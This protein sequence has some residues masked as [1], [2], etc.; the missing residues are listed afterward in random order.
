V[1]WFLKEHLPLALSSLLLGAWV[2][3][4][5]DL[6][7]FVFLAALFLFTMVFYLD[8]QIPSHFALAVSLAGAAI[9]IN[10][11]I[12]LIYDQLISHGRAY[13]S[14]NLIPIIPVVSLLCGQLIFVMKGLAFNS[15]R[16]FSSV[17]SVFGLVIS[18]ISLLIMSFG[19]FSRM[20]VK[21][22]RDWTVWPLL[23]LFAITVG[24]GLYLIKGQ[25]SDWKERMKNNSVWLV[26]VAVVLMVLLASTGRFY[27]LVALNLVMFLW[28]LA[29]IVSGYRS[30]NT[31]WFTLGIVAFTVFTITEYFNI[32]WEMLPKS[33]FFMVGGVVLMVGGALLERQRRILISSWTSLKGGSGDETRA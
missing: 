33:L 3:V 2:V 32:F 4:E 23:V 17:Y 16:N 11:E 10:K 19:E 13:S 6:S 24:A 7:P 12:Y 9:F 20:L 18:G 26:S 15:K 5:N 30:Q 1:A 14:E 31:V 21:L 22:S 25:D 27:P 8:Y 28:A 29:V